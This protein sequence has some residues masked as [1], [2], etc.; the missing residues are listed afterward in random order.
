M[1][2]ETLLYGKVYGAGALGD[3]CGSSLPGGTRLTLL[4]LDCHCLTLRSS[5]PGIAP[6]I[7]QLRGPRD[8]PLPGHGLQGR[9][10][11]PDFRQV[12]GEVQS[13]DLNLRLINQSSVTHIYN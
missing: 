8:N 13:I 10:D 3:S 9:S 12:I 1:I 4:D 5:P 7:G 6:V 2:E 11:R